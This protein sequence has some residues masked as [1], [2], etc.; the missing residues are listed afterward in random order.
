MGF[1]L[2]RKVILIVILALVGMATVVYLLLPQGESPIA[3]MW[4]VKKG[5]GMT[6]G[7]VTQTAQ[8][9]VAWG[10]NWGLN[11]SYFN[12]YWQYVP[13]IHKGTDIARIKEMARNRP[14]IYWLVWNEPDQRT[15]ENLQPA[16]AARNYKKIYDAIMSVDPTAKLIVGGVSAPTSAGYG[17]IRMFRGEY[18]KLYRAWPKMAGLHVHNYL[19]TS[20]NT[21]VWRDTL[22]MFRRWMDA[23]RIGGELW[24]TEY[25]CLKWWMLC[26]QVMREQ[27]P[28]LETQPWLHRYAWFAT[29]VTVPSC[30]GCYGSLLRNGMLTDLGILYRGY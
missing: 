2:M 23:D 5:V 6:S 17:W 16:D 29:N 19:L 15:Q 13:M 12:P 4:S 7:T 8:L 18:Y 20:Y 14:G 24:L 27:T 30:A 22:Y 11:G 10:Y 9:N 1:I 25:G 28:W 26:E 3:T 21:K